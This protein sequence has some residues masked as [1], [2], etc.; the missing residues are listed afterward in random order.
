MSKISSSKRPVPVDCEEG[1]ASDCVDPSPQAAS[2]TRDCLSN[3]KI[4]DRSQ[5]ARQEAAIKQGLEE[6]IEIG[7]Q[8]S[9][10][11]IKERD[12]LIKTQNSHIKQLTAEL[13]LE[14]AH[15]LPAGQQSDLSATSISS[16]TADNNRQ[17][18]ENAQLEPRVSLSDA[19]N[20]AVSPDS[21]RKR[22]KS[23]LSLGKTPDCML[24]LPSS[25]GSILRI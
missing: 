6:G 14:A 17:R 22:K 18:G 3:L 13:V 19:A 23:R 16:L 8:E 9:A 5:K 7:K 20:W 25:P 24:R 15:L 1:E 2:P 21:P 10:G 11:K 4:K 12:T